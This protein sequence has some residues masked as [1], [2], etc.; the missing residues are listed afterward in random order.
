[1]ETGKTYG[2][3]VCF[4]VCVWITVWCELMFFFV[5]GGGKYTLAYIHKYLHS[6]IVY[7]FGFCVVFFSPLTQWARTNIALMETHI[8]HQKCSRINLLP[9]EDD[10]EQKSENKNEEESIWVG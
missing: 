3:Y 7:D 10:H 8:A 6:I 1:M 2:P 5:S 4:A 9:T